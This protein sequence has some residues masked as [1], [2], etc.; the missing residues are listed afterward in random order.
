[1]STMYFVIVIGCFVVLPIVSII[2]EVMVRRR[3]GTTPDLLAIALRWF[4]FWIVGVRLLTAGVSQA[5]QPGF[6]AQTIFGTDDPQVLPFISELGYANIAMGTIG[7]LSVF[8]RGWT[9]PAAVVGAVFLGLDGIRHVVE[10]GEFTPDRV[11]ATAT[12]L[13]ALVVLGGAVIA[14]AVRGRRRARTME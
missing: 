4:T 13:L 3:R 11:L 8:L 14:L 12:D 6:T 1:M 9:I 10:G 7:I 2:V 5:I